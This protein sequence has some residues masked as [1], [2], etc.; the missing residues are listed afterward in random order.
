MDWEEGGYRFSDKDDPAI[1]ASR[2]EIL[3]GGTLVTTG[4]LVDESNPDPEIVEKNEHDF[5][6]DENGLRWFYTGDIGKVSAN[7]SIS[8][9]DRKKDLVKLQQG[10]YVALSKVLVRF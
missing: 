7:G 2:G 1:G 3:I 9:I 6:T 8:I 5:K 4:Y 10:E